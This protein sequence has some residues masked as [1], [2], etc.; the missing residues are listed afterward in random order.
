MYLQAAGVRDRESTW[1]CSPCRLPVYVSSSHWMSLWQVWQWQYWLH[2]ERPGAQLLLLQWNERIK[3]SG[4]F[5]LP[6]LVWRT[7]TSKKFVCTC[8]QAANHYER[9]HWS[10][11]SCGGGAPGM[12]SAGASVLSPLNPVFWVWF[13]KFYSVF[14]FFKLLNEFYYI[15][16]CTMIITAQFYRISIPNPQH[17]PPSPNLSHKFFKV[18]ESVSTQSYYLK[19]MWVFS[20]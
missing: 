15:Y 13:H 2:R 19:D 6:T 9:P 11:L 7:K 16:N 3:S 14:F 4:H 5:M 20:V 1:L 12:Q 17:R 10:L 8:A 18:R